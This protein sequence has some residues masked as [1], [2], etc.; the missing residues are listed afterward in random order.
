MI[1]RGNMF[2][3]GCIGVIVFAA[4]WAV[5]TWMGSVW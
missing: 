2:L 4:G 5:G 3:I 1:H